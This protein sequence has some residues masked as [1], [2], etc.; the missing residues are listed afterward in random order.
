MKGFFQKGSPVL[1]GTLLFCLAAGTSDAV[2]VVPNPL[3]Q[4]MMDSVSVTRIEAHLRALEGF[5]TRHFNSDTLS[6]TLGI[7]AA[8]RY[9]F[10]QF[11]A[12]SDSNGGRLQVGYFDF[13]ATVFG[14]TRLHRNV[15]A[16]LPGTQ[17]PDS[18][19][20]FIVSG[21]MDS[22]CGSAS[23]FNCFAPGAN[24]DGSGSV[25]SIELAQVLA[26]HQFDATLIFMTVTGEDVGLVGSTHYADS[27]QL[28]GWDLRGMIT[29]D[30]VGNIKGEPGSIID[31]SSVRHFSIG[32]STSSSRQLTRYVKLKGDLYTYPWPLTINLILSQDRPG[33]GGDHIPFNDNGYA[34]GR[35]TEPNENLNNQHS[36]NDR[37][38]SLS[39]NYVA[40]IVRLN[41]AYYA[42]LGWGPAQPESVQVLDVGNGTDVFVTWTKN[43]EPDTAEYR[44]AVRG[45]N[46]TFYDT[47][48]S[49]G[50][51]NQF[52]VT[53][54]T[55]GDS[56][57]ISVSAV[58]SGGDEGLF[59]QEV[60]ASPRSF[61]MPPQNLTLTPTWTTLDLQWLPNSEL[62]IAGYNIYRSLTPDTG[63]VQIDSVPHPT[64]TYSDSN[65]TPLTWYYYRVTA[66]DTSSLEGALSN[67]VRGR[68]L[69]MDQGILVV[70]ETRDG[71]GSPPS[72]TDAQV[73][74]F[75]ANILSGYTF[76]EWDYNSLGA[77]SLSDLG[78]YSTVLWHGGDL[79]DQQIYP[80]LD[81][82][83]Q[84][85]QQGGNLW[86][87]GWRP[88]FALMNRQGS[89]PYTFTPGQFPYDYLHLSGSDEAPTVDFSGAMGQ[90]GYSNF[91][92]DT[93]KVP[94]AWAGKL[95]N[96]NTT[97]PRD[98]EAIFTFNSASGDT[99]FQ[100]EPCGVRYLTGS[101]K[102]V[103]FG[104]PFYFMNES[105]A[106]LVAGDVLDDLGEVVG[107]EEENLKFN[108]KNFHLL[109][110]QPNPFYGKTT[111][112]YQIPTRT[113]VHLKIY[114][115]TGR[116]VQVLVNEAQKAGSQS[117][118]WDGKDS[119]GKG[120]PSG[121]YFYKLDAGDFKSTKKLIYLK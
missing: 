69:S 109:Q 32:P 117:I 26:P 121:V 101:Y 106:R 11:Q 81:P 67:E 15:V 83:A 80:N 54:L 24:D 82:L 94:P 56:F 16:I 48:F 47:I 119:Q 45:I 120:V 27:I 61:P 76:T 20:I 33:R 21:H 103:F 111:I 28:W 25:A 68:L 30:V 52:T 13:I 113:H 46:S 95:V 60:F 92:V 41:A 57:Y 99:N 44:V 10:D 14:I 96:S 29:N 53:G 107:V 114:D 104:F 116:M 77:L 71:S 102:I 118:L 4:E 115:I 84:Y 75:Y 37:V 22:R 40:Q 78:A 64:N 108:V 55:E 105:E 100:G 59:S 31:S 70:D 42:S 19:R 3:I 85:L 65:V 79:S 87:V 62:D 110:N 74:D 2:Q 112:R 9:I 34:A 7:G 12:I 18:N 91:T 5:Y 72:P 98:A 97:L 63:F 35:H 38:D 51:T 93:T 1:W 49:A 36:A 17:Q 8:R 73:D 23:D 50:A 66:V 86:L 39:V 90:L 88:I 89:F 43:I 58:D 6:D